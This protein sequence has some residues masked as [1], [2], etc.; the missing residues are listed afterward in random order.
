MSLFR[1]RT[2]TAKKIAC[3][4]KRDLLKNPWANIFLSQGYRFLV[5]GDPSRGGQQMVPPLGMHACLVPPSSHAGLV[6]AERLMDGIEGKAGKYSGLAEEYAVPLV[7]AVGARRFTGVTLGHLDDV[8]KG[9]PAPKITFQFDAGD[10]YGSPSS[11]TPRGSRLRSARSDRLSDMFG[12]RARSWR[13]SPWPFTPSRRSSLAR[14]SPSR[15]KKGS[16][17]SGGSPSL[18]LAH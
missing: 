18:A 14:D 9:L 7:V 12:A 11:W 8:L 13:G 15:R 6:S 10:P 1:L 4:L 3:D 5:M 2:G 16:G 17:P